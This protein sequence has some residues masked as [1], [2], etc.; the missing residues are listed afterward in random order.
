MVQGFLNYYK[1]KHMSIDLYGI[2]EAA[3]VN[4]VAV[5]LMNSVGID[6]SNYEPTQVDLSLLNSNYDGIITIT[7]EAHEVALDKYNPANIHR[8]S[9]IEVI[10]T[11]L[12]KKELKKA[13]KK[14]RKNIQIFCE[15]FVERELQANK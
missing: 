13:L 10:D 8:V 9:G 6:I 12:G 2:N 11:S 7:G 1:P 15:Q 14:A 5:S 3:K 4:K